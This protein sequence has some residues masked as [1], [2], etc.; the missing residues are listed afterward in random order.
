[1]S[2]SYTWWNTHL[3]NNKYPDAN[4]IMCKFEVWKCDSCWKWVLKSTQC[5]EFDKYTSEPAHS[6]VTVQSRKWMIVHGVTSPS[7]IAIDALVRTCPECK[8]KNVPKLKRAV[9]A[10]GLLE[11]L[12]SMAGVVTVKGP[13]GK[14]IMPTWT[15]KNVGTSMTDSE[16]ETETE[17]VAD[18]ESESETDVESTIASKNA[19]VATS[20]P[21]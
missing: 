12:Q 11:V 18:F 14:Q 17:S 1:M 2:N 9:L 20:K 16:I 8:P 19:V 10:R 4:E 3:T 15:K 5:V 6:S 7:G 13:S 21:E